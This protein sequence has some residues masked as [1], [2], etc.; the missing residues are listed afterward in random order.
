MVAKAL[1]GLLRARL[2]LSEALSLPDNGEAWRHMEHARARVV[3]W[4]LKLEDEGPAK[5][6]E[7]LA[8]LCACEHARALC[9]M[10]E[11]PDEML[12][13]HEIALRHHLIATIT[14]SLVPSEL[15]E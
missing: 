14:S 15:D 11:G 4:E 1:R 2:A 7:S 13:P 5:N 12:D 8:L 6:P 10:L 9:A 3:R